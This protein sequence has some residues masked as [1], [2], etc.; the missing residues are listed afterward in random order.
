MDQSRLALPDEAGTVA[1]AHHAQ[2][3]SVVPFG[4]GQF[5]DHGHAQRG[6]GAVVLDDHLLGR[7]EGPEH[8]SDQL[9]GA[10]GHAGTIVELL[11]KVFDAPA[12]RAPGG[13]PRLGTPV[14]PVCNGQ[15]RVVGPGDDRVDVGDG[16]SVVIRGEVLVFVKSYGRTVRFIDREPPIRHSGDCYA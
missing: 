1:H 11:V 10:V 13:L 7:V 8:R 3:P 6:G 16:V 12:D 5:A 14:A 15:H 4:L 2:S 9:L